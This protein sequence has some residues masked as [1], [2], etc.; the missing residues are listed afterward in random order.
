ML[1]T[2]NLNPSQLEKVLVEIGS[3]EI[4]AD[5]TI[6][7]PVDDNKISFW[8]PNLEPATEGIVS[9]SPILPPSGSQSI[10]RV[11]TSLLSVQPVIG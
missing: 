1:A 6:E 3:D 4:E 9:I 10:R 2:L 8:I 5:I 7:E 11:F